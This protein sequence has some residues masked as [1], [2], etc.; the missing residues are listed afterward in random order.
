MDAMEQID[1]GMRVFDASG[2]EIGVVEELKMG[3]PGA[4]TSRCQVAELAP[5]VVTAPSD[6][7]IGNEPRVPAELTD[8]LLRKGYL[9]IDGKGFLAG[10]SYAS[11]DEV[12]HVVGDRVYLAVDKRDLVK[13]G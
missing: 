1:G 9:K 8:R 5:A 2:E 12:D 3:D 6:L 7:G 11:A 4:V 10:S 13:P